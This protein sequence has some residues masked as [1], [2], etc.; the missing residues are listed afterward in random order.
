[1]AIYALGDLEPVIDA[2]AYVHP[3]ATVIGD[4]TLGPDS[5]VW[6][7]PSYEPITAGS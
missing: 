4:V 3:Q 5:T 2:R 6:P 7:S 1:M